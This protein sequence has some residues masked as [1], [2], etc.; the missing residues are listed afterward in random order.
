M[1]FVNED[2]ILFHLISINVKGLK[3]SVIHSVEPVNMESSFQLTYHFIEAIACAASG[4]LLN[5]GFPFWD[6][7]LSVLLQ[8]MLAVSTSK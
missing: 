4:I 2:R 5:M 6:Y 7:W 1:F 3:V 8:L